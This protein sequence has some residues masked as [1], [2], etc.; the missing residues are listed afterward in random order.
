MPILE[1]MLLGLAPVVAK[2][3]LAL[4]SKDTGARINFETDAASD[5][6]AFFASRT[7]DVISHR[8][9]ARSFGV[10][11]IGDRI[12][13]SL[14][15]VLE[16]EAHHLTEDGKEAIT[17]ALSETL[18]AGGV[19][20]TLI[21]ERNLDPSALLRY[22][23]PFS[24]RYTAHLSSAELAVFEILLGETVYYIV[25]VSSQLP[26]FSEKAFGEVL[27]REDLIINTVLQVLETVKVIR[28]D[29]QA[30]NES[31]NETAFEI[32]YRRRI[33]QRF[34][35]LQL[36]GVRASIPSNKYELTVAYITLK[37]SQ[38][39]AR[40]QDIFRSIELVLENGKKFVIRGAAGSGKTTLLQWIAVC[41][42][43]SCFPAALDKWNNHIPFFVRLR[44]FS[45]KQLPS[46]SELVRHSLAAISGEPSGWCEKILMEGR[47]IFLIDGVDELPDRLHA[48][49]EEWLGQL[50]DQFPNCYFVVT[51]RPRAVT[52]TWLSEEQFVS[53]ELQPM[54]L[55]TIESF[56][57]KWH[58]AVKLDLSDDTDKEEVASLAESLKHTVKHKKAIQEL[59]T[60]P[61]LCAMI[62]ALHRARH[63]DLPTRRDALY[64][65]ACQ[66]LV[67]DRDRL[68]NIPEGD[69]PRLDYEQKRVLLKRLAY[70]M[71]TNKRVQVSRRQAE[72][73]FD[74][75]LKHIRGISVDV[76][77]RRVY[78]L[79]V[80]RSGIVRE[81]Q[82]DVLDFAHR[83]FLEY[84]AA[85][86]IH[87]D[88]NIHELIERAGDEQ[89]HEVLLLAAAVAETHT[90]EQI[91]REL[92]K[93]GENSGQEFYYLLA[94]SCSEARAEID[95]EITRQIEAK[96]LALIPPQTAR[97][98]DRLAFA[99]KLAAPYLARKKEYSAKQATMCIRALAAIRGES[100]LDAL[101]TYARDRRKSVVREL[102]GAWRAF[103]TKEF[104]LRILNTCRVLPLIGDHDC[105]GIRWLKN[106]QELR[107]I[108]NRR[109]EDVA[110]LAQL[111]QLTTVILRGCSIL[112]DISGLTG[113]PQILHLELSGCL[114]LTDISP[115]ITLRSLTHLSLYGCTGLQDLSPLQSLEHLSSLDIRMTIRAHDLSPL[116]DLRQLKVLYLDSTTLPENVGLLRL[117][118]PNTKL[119]FDD[120]L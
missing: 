93:K 30:A 22:Y 4:W 7:A 15:E 11:G 119:V 8:Q 113:L 63:R 67:E 108:D 104:A 101:N 37:V 97:D 77:A 16:A 29:S 33:E 68:R 59:A 81:P 24:K 85:V 38:K 90:R 55:T 5:L 107:I 76:T 32:L 52:S 2:I 111:T 70:W 57:D 98:A 49:V 25:E 17:I 61:L 47:G 105:T 116:T 120:L 89:W 46:P 91:I 73:Q 12:I 88:G 99:G 50:L 23:A 106:V 39:T 79:L 14:H 117:E 82:I 51:S 44:E 34:G 45:S 42:A 9:G 40:G 62:C 78:N 13:E 100:A 28:E 75:S 86:A 80:E 26:G 83:T 41:A 95:P 48:T 84:L 43:T 69:H 66:L 53:G 92:M 71:L 60:N 6:I 96:I 74:E 19:N 27:R 114:R 103:N 3:I 115:L 118:L 72:T 10:G 21:I 20:S 18:K 65:A 1:S 102:V 58:S 110:F 87:D 31:K 35:K 54:D 94:S 109:M 64:E 112:E 36:L 56:I